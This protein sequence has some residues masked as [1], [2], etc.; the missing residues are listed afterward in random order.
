M[1]QRIRGREN[2]DRVQRGSVDC[3]AAFGANLSTTSTGFS[4]NAPNERCVWLRSA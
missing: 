1:W 3:I 4:W 2:L